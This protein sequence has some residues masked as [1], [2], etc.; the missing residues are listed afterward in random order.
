MSTTG[1]P[2]GSPQVVDP[3]RRNSLL[4]TRNG[5]LLWLMVCLF[6]AGLLALG[7]AYG[8]LPGGAKARRRRSASGH[9]PFLRKPAP[10]R[11]WLKAS[12][13]WGAATNF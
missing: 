8:C 6:Q 12:A 5:L 9:R 2:G 10:K 1:A 3:P 7:M 11:R 4:S 13:I